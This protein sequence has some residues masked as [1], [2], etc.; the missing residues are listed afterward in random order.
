[1]TQYRK[2]SNTPLNPGATIKH[3]EG[4]QMQCRPCAEP[5]GEMEIYNLTTQR[6]DDVAVNYYFRR[7][8]DVCRPVQ[9]EMQRI[10]DDHRNDVAPN[11][12]DGYTENTRLRVRVRPPFDPSAPGSPTRAPYNVRFFAGPLNYLNNAFG[13]NRDQ[14]IVEYLGRYEGDVFIDPQ[15]GQHRQPAPPQPPAQPAVDANAIAQAVIAQMIAAQRAA[16]AQGG[17]QQGQGGPQGRPRQ[18][19]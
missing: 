12:F 7:D 17:G 5:D 15:G 1:M 18:R 11:L 10:I 16:Q 13:Y 14:C 3:V 6:N 8:T 4:K 9:S 19:R 2:I